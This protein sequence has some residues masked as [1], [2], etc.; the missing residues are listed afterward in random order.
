[1]KDF[2]KDY[3]TLVGSFVGFIFAVAAMFVKYMFDKRTS[4]NTLN[5]KIK[6]VERDDFKLKTAKAFG[7]S[8]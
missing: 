7:S 3:G 2:L 1:M 4:L 8:R 6:K 5:D